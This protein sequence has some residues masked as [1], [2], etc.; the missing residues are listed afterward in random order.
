MAPCSGPGAG[1]TIAVLDPVAAHVSAVRAESPGGV[2]AALRS[3]MREASAADGPA[4]P[5][6]LHAPHHPLLHRLVRGLRTRRL[7]LLAAPTGHGKS[8]LALAAAV[9]LELPACLVV[10]AALR[11]Q[12]QRLARSIGIPYEILT[13]ER[14]SR[15]PPALPARALVIVD[16]AHRF[17]TPAT[18]RYRHLASRLTTRP[19][20]LLT[21]TPVVNRLDDL[22][23]LLQLGAADDALRRDGVPSLHRL[24]T[25]GALHPALAHL[26]HAPPGLARPPVERLRHRP[27][28]GEAR[29]ALRAGAASLTFSRDP[30]VAALLRGLALRALASS[31]AAFDAVL[32]RCERLHRHAAEAA[33]AGHPMSRAALLRA[34]RQLDD[35]LLIWA[36]LPADDAPADLDAADL[37]R[38]AR[39]RADC[40]VT[41]PADLTPVLEI[42]PPDAPTIVF[43]CWR[44]TAS[45]LVRRLGARTAWVTG[46]A[47]G[48]GPMRLPRE[49][50][51]AHFRAPTTDPRAPR[52][53]VATDVAAEGLDL[54]RLRCVIHADLP[55]TPTR[56]TQREG[57][58]RRA[59][60][61][62]TVQVH[63]L[64]PP[65]P[66]ERELRQLGILRRKR[67]VADALRRS[68]RLLPWELALP[69]DA[70]ALMPGMSERQA[71]PPEGAGRP[72]ACRIAMRPGVLPN[73]PAA[74]CLFVDEQGE[75]AWSLV[76]PD[77]PAVTETPLLNRALRRLLA[78]VRRDA[79]NGAEASSVTRS[80]VPFRLPP[81]LATAVAT[82]CRRRLAL[83]HTADWSLEP[84]TLESRVLIARLRALGRAAV[85][86]RDAAQL[87]RLDRALRWCARGPTAG[88]R[89]LQQ[90]LLTAPD[91][92]AALAQADAAGR[93]AILP[94]APAPSLR[95]VAVCCFVPPRAAATFGP[96]PHPARSSST[97]TAR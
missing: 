81:A 96:C 75:A 24:L 70:A 35:Q 61:P 44:A 23:A 22:L 47:S 26:V 20:L 29:T 9:Q 36:V 87:A 19:L 67:A 51:L 18:R 84:A 30:A 63:L 38:L 68:V 45:A 71:Q 8:Y 55:W 59:G 10:P 11:P 15:Q 2:L 91:L 77:A 66:L 25:A 31:I 53:L 33:A 12:W 52:V 6:W 7:A 74:L 82:E 39:L 40:A 37:P 80:P 34:T 76:L 42:V 1:V 56:M 64:L 73:L 83:R 93:F 49:V 5:I 50:V 46:D 21:A 58:A 92:A 27:A 28:L 48:I 16:E 69:S 94:P 97:S 3:V 17:R 13:H 32:A 89:L 4:A 88:D 65:A 90:T 78:V 41:A 60:V 57:R 85:R 86:T 54:R 95:L 62:E 14:L 79:T 43:T 72:L